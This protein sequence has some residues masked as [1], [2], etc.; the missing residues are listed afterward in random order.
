M[1]D[2]PFQAVRATIQRTLPGAPSS[3]CAILPTG[4]TDGAL[5][6]SERRRALTPDTCWCVG[7]RWAMPSSPA[8]LM[9]PGL[10]RSRVTDEHKSN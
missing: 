5:P 7:C 1:T 8:G 9:T 4:G 3:S 2:V 6:R 10:V